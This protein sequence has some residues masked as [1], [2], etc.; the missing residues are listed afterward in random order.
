MKDWTVMVYMAGDND[1]EDAAHGDLFEM[2]KVGSSKQVDIVVQ[3]DSHRDGTVRYHVQPQRLDLVGQPLPETNTGDPIVLTRFI[4]WARRICPAHHNLLVIWNHGTG[5][6]DVRAS[7]NWQTIR[8]RRGVKEKE[9]DSSIFASTIRKAHARVSGA[10]AIALDATSRDF[11]D[12][13]ELK[14]GLTDA[15][16]GDRLDVLGFDACLMGLI[17]IGYQMRD[18]ACFMVGSQEIEPHFGWPYEPILKALGQ[19]PAMSPREVAEL[20]VTSY[21]QMGVDEG[22]APTKYTQSAFDLTQIG[23]TFDLVKRLANHLVATYPGE[24]M[25]QRAVDDASSQRKGAKRFRDG[26]IVDFYDWIWWVRRFYT[27]QDAE[28]KA[29]L[30]PLLA[31][32]TPEA[33]GGLI[34]ANVAEIG[35]DREHVHG[36][37]IYLPERKAYSELYQDLD[38]AQTGWG[39]FAR[40]VGETAK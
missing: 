32:L 25:V 19:N 10:R 8:G 38:F 3:L 12:N 6:E 23:T 7:F 33:E 2:L 20:I 29:A 14:R 36:A 24:L 17:E 11:L 18:L 22:R 34:V 15:L 39:H 4:R 16:E 37:S 28:F 40:K 1:L 27:G 26:N 21:G 31:H 35:D 13:D 5:W 30:D 9:L